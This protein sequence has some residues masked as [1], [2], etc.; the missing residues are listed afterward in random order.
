ML[1]LVLALGGVACDSG[2]TVTTPTPTPTPDRVTETFS[3]TLTVNSAVTFN[4]TSAAAG[5]VTVTLKSVT[6]SGPNLGVA[7]GTWNGVLC[8]VVLANDNT[9]VG[10]TVTGSVTGSGGL[11]ARV[12]DV[13]QLSQAVG[14]EIVVTHP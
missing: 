13:G 5:L 6:P 4:F 11:C 10:T 3:G 7:L 9:A 12:Y 8:Q 2:D 14:F 1:A